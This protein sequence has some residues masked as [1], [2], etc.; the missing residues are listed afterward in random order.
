MIWLG[1]NFLAMLLEVS[2]IEE[3]IDKLEFIKFKTCA[4]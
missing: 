3:Q 2:S 1:K 4:L